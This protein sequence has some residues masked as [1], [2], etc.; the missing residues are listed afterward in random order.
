LD[1]AD[2]EAIFKKVGGGGG[3]FCLLYIYEFFLTLST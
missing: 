2:R 1:R 3:F